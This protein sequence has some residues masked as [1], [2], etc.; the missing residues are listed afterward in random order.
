MTQWYRWTILA[1]ACT[2]LS[3]RVGLAARVS[4]DLTDAEVGC[5]YMQLQG[6][7][8]TIANQAMHVQVCGQWRALSAGAASNVFEDVEWA[9][10]ALQGQKLSDADNYYIGKYTGSYKY[11]KNVGKLLRGTAPG[12]PWDV[13]DE[14]FWEVQRNDY[15]SLARKVLD[16]GAGLGAALNKLPSTG[17][18]DLWRGAWYDSASVWQ[19]HKLEHSGRALRQSW[20]QSTTV[21]EA[22]SYDFMAP[23][24]QP[25]YCK[26]DCIAKAKEFP[27]HFHLRTAAAKDVRQWNAAEAELILL[28]NTPFRV[29][30]VEKVSNDPL[31]DMKQPELVA[32]LAGK[33]QAGAEKDALLGKIG[34][35][36]AMSGPMFVELWS[37]ELV[38]WIEKRYGVGKPSD[39]YPVLKKRFVLPMKGS[40]P[41]DSPLFYKVTLEDA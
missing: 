5:G 2:L 6:A 10:P 3:V 32:W 7:G 28:P 1:L 13:G 8:V 14:Q 41:N 39:L 34:A 26:P 37:K 33:L 9:D 31:V 20:F 12:V 30:S 21:Q 11:C 18:M 23:M 35:D 17:T 29:K 40:T 15:V 22:H 27:V 4:K 25:D 19:L 38:Y 24:Y 16:F 36:P